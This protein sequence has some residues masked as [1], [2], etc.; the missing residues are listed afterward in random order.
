MAQPLFLQ[1]VINSPKDLA[2]RNGDRNGT[3]V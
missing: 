1:T 3:S 2:E